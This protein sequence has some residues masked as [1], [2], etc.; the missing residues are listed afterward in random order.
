M[1]EAVFS[2]VKLVLSALFHRKKIEIL[3]GGTDKVDAHHVSSCV[4]YCKEKIY[5]MESRYKEKGL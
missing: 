4:S 5:T 2:C 3:L 1:L